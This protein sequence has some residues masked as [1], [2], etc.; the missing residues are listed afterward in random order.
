MTSL[1]P[2]EAALEYAAFGW[3]VLPIH[4]VHESMCECGTYDE[5]HGVGKAPYTQHNYKDATDDIIQISL[6]W[7]MWPNANIAIATGSKSKIIV[8][9]I[10]AKNN[11]YASLNE[12]QMRYG[13]IP[14]TV[15]AKSGGGG[16][17]FYFKAP[18]RELRGRIGMRP[19]IDVM[20]E[21]QRIIAPPSRHKSG[22]RY[23]WINSPLNWEIAE[24]PTW[25]LR[26]MKTP[27]AP[28]KRVRRTR[29]WSDILN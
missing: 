4:G 16:K 7:K 23:E 22:N 10:D 3:K 21:D 8:M 13:L 15:T 17:H 5:R 14:Q 26:I 9:D 20:A 27:N 12:L 24:I 19:G 18:L 25:L 6:W 28:Q 1:E 29:G 2:F 11:G